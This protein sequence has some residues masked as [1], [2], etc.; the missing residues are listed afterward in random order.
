MKASRYRQKYLA[1]LK[2]PIITKRELRGFEQAVE[3]YKT[4]HP[5]WRDFDIN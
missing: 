3:H 4:V 2:K 5:D 1:L